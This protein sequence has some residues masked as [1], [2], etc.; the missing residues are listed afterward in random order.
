MTCLKDINCF[1]N[2]FILQ[3]DGGGNLTLGLTRDTP[4][5]PISYCQAF[6]VFMNRVDNSWHREL[7]NKPMLISQLK[8][9]P[10][11]KTLHEATMNL[12]VALR[13]YL[14]AVKKDLVK[15]NANGFH[16]QAT[17][18]G[19]LDGETNVSYT[20]APEN[21]SYSNHKA[22]GGHLGAIYYESTRRMGFNQAHAPLCL[23]N[24][25]ESSP[26]EPFAE[27]PDPESLTKE[28]EELLARLYE[29]GKD[30]NDNQA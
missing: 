26:Y 19:R 7:H 15:Y 4:K 8:E 5:D 24:I 27:R 6:L 14:Y 20:F 25:A 3:H 1:Y 17:A 13:A 2:N 12:E 21:S 11:P 9:K 18:Y 30:A 29:E 22:T 28:D 10:M 23:P 16:F